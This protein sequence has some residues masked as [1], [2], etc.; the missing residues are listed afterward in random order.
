MVS[1]YILIM[2]ASGAEQKILEEMKLKPT[3]ANA[4][5]VY[6]EWDIIAKVNATS[7]EGINNFVI[8]TVRPISDIEK[9][10]TL[11]TVG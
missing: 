2:C 7:I 4:A 6:G 1:A 3:V 8:Q 5:I 9:T 10:A 11:I